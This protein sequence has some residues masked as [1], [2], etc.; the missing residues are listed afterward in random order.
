MAGDFKRAIAYKLRIGDVF[1]GKKI[2][3]GERFS[4][5]ELGDKRIS[6][7]NIVANVVEKYE[8][9]EKQYISFTIDDASGQLRI[10]VF[11][12]DVNRCRHIN[13]GDTIMIL[14]LLR[15]YNNEVYI[16]PEIMKVKDPRY[17][18]VRKLE[19]EKEQPKP[20]D[21]QKVLAVADQIIKKIK[22]SEPE[23]IGTDKLIEQLH[24]STD[25]INQE[26]RKALEGG[27]I[28]EPRP[29]ILRYLGN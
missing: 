5:L 4:F 8:S 26:V 18:L 2:L 22:D 19:I 28:Y 15:D 17:L 27:I 20:V 13:Q 21:N 24:E 3:D 16:T 14:G 6:R 25:L 29:G 10:K 1:K 23:G 7:V 12:N 9:G 11:G